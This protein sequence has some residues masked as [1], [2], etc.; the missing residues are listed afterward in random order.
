MDKDVSADLQLLVAAARRILTEGTGEMDVLGCVSVRVPGS[1]HF[2]VSSYG[3]GAVA[4]PGDVVRMNEAAEVVEGSATVSSAAQVQAAIYRRRPSVGAIV[5]SHAHHA[6]AVASSRRVIGTYNELSTLFHGEQ[7]VVED[8][9]DRSSEAAERM[10]EAL[11]AY[12]V[13]LLPNHGFTVVG[14]T[15]EEATVD[16]VAVEKAARWHVQAVALAGEEVVPLHIDQIKPMYEQH[17]RPNTWTASLRRLRRAAPD[18]FAEVER[19]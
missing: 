13:M 14:A 12:R 1:D 15:L 11:G 18:L 5:H 8:D 19:G 10:A 4:E 16:A 7:V 6:A 9:G 17:F 2:W 3:Y